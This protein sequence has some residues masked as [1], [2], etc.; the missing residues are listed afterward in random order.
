MITNTISQSNTSFS[1]S[2]NLPQ[3]LFEKL[4]PNQIRVAR[5]ILFYANKS[6]GYCLKSYQTIANELRVSYSTVFRTIQILKEHLIRCYRI[7]NRPSKIYANPELK[8]AFSK[9]VNINDSPMTVPDTPSLYIKKEKDIERTID[10]PAPR[11][12]PKNCFASV[13]FS[14]S[15][16]LKEVRIFLKLIKT[17]RIDL[18]TL[19][20]SADEL[21]QYI[22]DRNVDNKGGLLRTILEAKHKRAIS[23]KEEQ[24]SKANLN[25]PILPSCEVAKVIYPGLAGKVLKNGFV[26]VQKIVQVEQTLEIKEN[27]ATSW[28]NNMRKKFN[29]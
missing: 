11:S 25:D 1:D 29:L 27:I 6:W 22:R 21:R 12:K 23:I 8:A 14:L 10:K 9:P 4:T 7:P 28:L 20:Q 16:S 26:D 17:R 2:C 19:K 15:L 13:L 5:H 24:R 3:Y 18:E